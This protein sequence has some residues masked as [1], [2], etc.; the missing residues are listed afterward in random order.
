[1]YDGKMFLHG[2]WR[3]LPVPA[4]VPADLA[5]EPEQKEL[6]SL[7]SGY[8]RSFDFVIINAPLPDESG[9][10]FAIDTSCLKNTVVLLLVRTGIYDTIRYETPCY[11]VFVLPN[12]VSIPAMAQ[13]PDWIE[14]ARKRLCLFEKKTSA[15]EQKMAEIRLVNRAK[16][17]LSSPLKLSEPD[18]CR[19]IEK[20]TMN[21]CV[22]NEV[23]AHQPAQTKR[24]GCL[25]IH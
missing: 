12:P 3:I 25:P 18:A 21:R 15:S 19:Y 22:P 11:G 20:Q 10:R 1:M 4:Q 2:D 16:W 6:S 14:S 7:L 8:C 24:T 13:V 17:Q 23:T 9:T 5:K